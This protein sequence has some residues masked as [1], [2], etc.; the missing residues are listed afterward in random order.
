[1][2]ATTSATR[3]DTDYL[4]LGAG[5]MSLAFV[6]VILAEDPDAD[7]VVVDRRDSPGGHWNDAYPFV[8]LH[9]PAAFYGLNSERLGAG[10]ADLASGPEVVAYFKRAMNRF[11]ATGRVRFL[12]MC[13]YRGEGRVVSTVDEDRA[14]EVTARRRVVDGTY[15]TVEVPVLRPPPYEVDAGVRV[16]P[17]NALPRIER[18]WQ[19]YVVV[20]AGKTG[21]DAILFL[22]DSGVAPERI[23]WIVSHEA[24]LWNR[25]TVQPGVVLKTFTAMVESVIAATDIDDVFLRLEREGVVFRIDPAGLPSKW[26]CAT[27]DERELNAL[28]RIENVIR[29]GRVERIG[30]ATIQLESGSV[31]AAADSL[32]IDCSANGLGRFE[33]QPLFSAGRITL[34][35]TFMCQQT[36]SAALTAHLELSD[37]TDAKRNRVC[38]AAPHPES[39]HDLP[40]ALLVSAQNMIDL[41]AHMPLWLRRSRLNPIHHD[42]VGRYLLGTTK[43]ALLQRKALAAMDGMQPELPAT[44]PGRG[45]R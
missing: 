40:S 44:S 45:P 38:R 4:V 22:L 16:V 41:H 7:L 9:Q 35:S 29:L 43:L 42:P 10:G 21:I 15:M 20:G 13:E 18:P 36:F 39:T 17:P 24:W 23:E 28:R 33:A 19:R 12:S 2:S 26:R 1:M 32:Y 31:D 6:D 8:T 3:L 5:A 14:F 37:L 30:A 27:I 34:Q 11:L 25:S